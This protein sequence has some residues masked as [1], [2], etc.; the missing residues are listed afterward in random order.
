MRLALLRAGE[1]LISA[2]LLTILIVLPVYAEQLGG[3]CPTIGAIRWDA[4]HGSRGEVGQAVERSLG[5]SHWHYR[6]PF[7][8]REL[9][10]DKVEIACDSQAAMDKEIDYAVQAGIGY[11]AFSASAPEDPMSLGLK[12][13]LSSKNKDKVKF[14]LLTLPGSWKRPD[15]IDRFVQLMKEPTYQKV[16]NNRPLF[17]VGFITADLLAVNQMNAEVFKEKILALRQK[18]RAAGLQDPYIVVMDFQPEQAKRLLNYYGFDAISSYAWPG[19]GRGAP[20]SQLVR[21]AE[22]NWDRYR[23][24][25][26]KVVPLVMTGWDNRPRAEHPAAWQMKNAGNLGKVYYE[27][28]KPQEIGNHVADAVRWVN[29]NGNAADARIVIIYAWNELDEGGWLVP[30]IAEGPARVEAVGRAMGSACR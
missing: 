23:D 28:A 16:I 4:W 24:T 19:P 13:Y 7:C 22:R 1:K 5:P 3:S 2:V 14:S 21:Q 18:A 15:S 29:A 12:Y 9:G 20:Y 11:W 25:G 17:F 10:Q 27:P 6:L 8:S 30:T 26:A